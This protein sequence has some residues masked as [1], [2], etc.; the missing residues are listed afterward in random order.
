MSDDKAAKNLYSET[1]ITLPCYHVIK[2][3]AEF[4]STLS[5]LNTF[6]K[7]VLYWRDIS[8][9]QVFLLMKGKALR[10]QSLH[11]NT[12]ASVLLKLFSSSYE[13]CHTTDAP[14]RMS[15]TPFSNVNKIHVHSMIPEDQTNITTQWCITGRRFTA[16][17]Q[18]LNTSCSKLN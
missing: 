8:C 5:L 3:H 2:I 16:A 14:L 7:L 11:E 1:G 9:I 6:I 10:K 12:A 15:G 13:W 18:A 4:R 17:T